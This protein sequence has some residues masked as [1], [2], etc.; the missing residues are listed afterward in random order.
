MQD[1]DD[2]N[3]VWRCRI[4]AAWP[5]HVVLLVACDDGHRDTPYRVLVPTRLIRAV[6]ERYPRE[7][8]A[9]LEAIHQWPDDPDKQPAQRR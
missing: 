1:G 2:V 3:D 5:S 4:A 7:D 8:R 9:R 6:R